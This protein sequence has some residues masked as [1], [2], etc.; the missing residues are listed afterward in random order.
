M[1]SRAA[2]IISDP[3]GLVNRQDG[4]SSNRVSSRP[5]VHM[6]LRRQC[7]FKNVFARLM[8]KPEGRVKRRGISQTRAH[9]LDKRHQKQ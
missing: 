4:I 5:E 9:L 6:T 2:R 8:W 7:G 1:W 3:M